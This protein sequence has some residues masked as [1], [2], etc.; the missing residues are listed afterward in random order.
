MYKRTR[1]NHLIKEVSDS[2]GC[3][4]TKDYDDDDDDDKIMKIIMVW[5]RY[6]RV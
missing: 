2:N 6:S 1:E 3:I 4:E 5:H